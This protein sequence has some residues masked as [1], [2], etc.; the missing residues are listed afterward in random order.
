LGGRAA[1]QAQSA[2]S[3]T[4][5]PDGKATITF[6]GYCLDFGQKFPDA[7]VAPNAVAA[8]NVRAALAYAQNQGL[9][10]D[11]QQA[12]EVQY[13]IWQLDGATNSPAGGATAKDVVANASSAPAAPQ[14]TSLIDAAKAN[15]V[16]LTV[17]SW[18]PLGQPVQLGSATDNFRGRG[19]LTVTNNSNQELNLY[20]PIGTVFGRQTAGQQ[21]IAAYATNIQVQAAQAAAQPTAAATTA[22]TPT[23]TPGQLPQTG[24][25]DSGVVWILA[26]LATLLFAGGLLAL[27]QLKGS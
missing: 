8:D 3:F 2:Q 11:E 5:A 18:Q 24:V 14:G 16:T 4:L 13:A 7:L 19:T 12:L 23:R 25:A 22:T 17:D 10:A 26:A 1:A 21:T 27:R 9:T 6:E 20:M 15:Q